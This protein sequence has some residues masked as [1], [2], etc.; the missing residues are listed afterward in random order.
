MEN[1]R[2]REIRTARLMIRMHCHAQHRR[3]LCDECVELL[4][5]AEKRIQ[6]CPFGEKKPICAH[7]RVHCYQSGMREKMVMV[8]RFSGP[9]MIW[10]HPVLVMLHLAGRYRDRRRYS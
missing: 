3:E 8:M 9:R 6:K 4:Q 10:R 5:Y 2:K 1:K 7:C